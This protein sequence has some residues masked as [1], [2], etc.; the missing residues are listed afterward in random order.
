LWY[1]VTML[2][3]LLILIIGLAVAVVLATAA[4]IAIVVS[5][6]WVFFALLDLKDFV[7]RKFTK[8]KQ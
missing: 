6:I 1:N 5:G 7:S 2:T 3:D 4:G 8:D